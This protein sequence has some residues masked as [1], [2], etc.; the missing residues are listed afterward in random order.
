VSIL[1][2]DFTEVQSLGCIVTIN[3]AKSYHEFGRLVKRLGGEVMVFVKGNTP[4]T[5]ADLEPFFEDE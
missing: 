4:A 2:S 3:A 5:R 1:K